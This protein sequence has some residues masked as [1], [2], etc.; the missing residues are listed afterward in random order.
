[1]N[2]KILISVSVIITI[3]II[4][5]SLTQNE[6]TEKQTSSQFEE[7]NEIQSMLNKVEQDRIKN[8]SSENKYQPKDRE[9]IKAG[10]FSID[11]SEYVLGE[12]IFVDITNL[13]KNAKGE[14]IFAKIIN[15]TTVHNYHMIKFDGA[16][17]QQNV[18]FQIQ[19]SK[20]LGF[21]TAEELVGDWGVY[22]QT[23]KV[24]ELPILNFK[25]KN[26]ILPGSE[27]NFESVC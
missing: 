11:R 27:D 10:P 20:Y 26:L 14:I 21:C 6:I 15:N 2:N 3:A 25:I 5:F 8:D 7:T 13:D 19:P 1:M 16:E 23:E 22:L 12:K 4:T 24:R 18:Y 17:Q 9:W